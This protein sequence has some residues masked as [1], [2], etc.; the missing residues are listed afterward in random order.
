MK[1]DMVSGTYLADKCIDSTCIH[2]NNAELL[3]EQHLVLIQTNPTITLSLRTWCT[4]WTVVIWTVVARH[5]TSKL[6]YIIGTVLVSPEQ[7]DHVQIASPDSNS[8]GSGILQTQGNV[9]VV[10]Q[11]S[12]VPGNS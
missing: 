10:V 1:S 2:A 4:Q 6:P 8:Q 7:L 3:Q 5:R 9:S 12:F 11:M